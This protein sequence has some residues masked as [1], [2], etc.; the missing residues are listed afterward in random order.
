MLCCLLRLDGRTEARIAPHREEVAP[1]IM[2]FLVY[3]QKLLASLPGAH[4]LHSVFLS[5]KSHDI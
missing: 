3:F 2:G 4:L 1:S 5:E